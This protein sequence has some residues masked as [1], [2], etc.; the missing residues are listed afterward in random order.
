MKKFLMYSF[1]ILLAFI[2]IGGIIYVIKNEALPKGSSSTEADQLAQKMLTALNYDAYKDTRYLKWTFRKRDYVWD[3]E[4]NL[5]DIKWDNTVVNLR[6]LIPELSNVFIN[7]E[8]PSA[9]DKTEAIENAIS[10][11]NN[12]SFWLIAPYKVM[13]PGTIRSLVT[14]NESTQGLKV[15]YSTGG[16]TPGDSYVWVLDENYIPQYYKMWVDIIPV[17]GLKAT[18][19]NFEEMESG[20]R[21]AQKREIEGL[22]E[23]PLSNVRAWN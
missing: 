10:R 22:M 23:I 19:I 12:D 21:I 1:G 9:K 4:N 15:T 7:G 13:D 8:I 14:L 6:I 17:G 18:W 3:R 11:F 16:T 5:V 20:A 2:V